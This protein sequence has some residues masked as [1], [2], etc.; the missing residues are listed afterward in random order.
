M[1][2]FRHRLR[3]DLPDPLTGDAVDLPDVV[4]RSRLPITQAVTQAHD[5]GFALAERVEY[6]PQLLLQQDER[7][8]LDGYNSL[9]VFDEITEL[10]R[11]LVTERLV[12]RDR[13]PCD[14]PNLDRGRNPATHRVCHLL[15][16]VIRAGYNPVRLLH[17]R[18]L[19]LRHPPH[20]GP[21]E[22]R[23]SCITDLNALEHITRTSEEQGVHSGPPRLM[24]EIAEHA[25][26]RGYGG[27][28]YLAI[29]ELF[30]KARP[31]S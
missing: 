22:T 10:G 20:P 29:Y 11:A 30:K 31:R 24:K 1:T 15:H 23:D 3:L 14:L 21:S 9:G 27:Q 17:D 19:C 13:F 12:Q 4:E 25:I 18:R 7:Y 16:K 26:A 6:R 2:Y 28:E 5:T 8:L